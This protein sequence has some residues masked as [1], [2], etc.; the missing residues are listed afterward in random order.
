MSALPGGCEETARRRAEH[1]GEHALSAF[2]RATSLFGIQA[3]HL[4]IAVGQQRDRPA[5]ALAVVEVAVKEKLIAVFSK[6]SAVIGM[7]R[8][9]PLAVPVRHH[10]ERETTAEKRSEVAEDHASLAREGRR[11]V[12]NTDKKRRHG[13]PSTFNAC[14]GAIL[15]AR[16]SGTAHAASPTSSMMP[17]AASSSMTWRIDSSPT[18]AASPL[19]ASTPAP[20]WRNARE[21][22]PVTMRP[23][24]APS[25][26]RIP[27]SRVR[28]ATVNDISEWMPVAERSNTMNVINH[29]TAVSVQLSVAPP[30]SASP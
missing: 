6:Q 8:Q 24:P 7:R 30:T 1:V 10:G 3:V 12:M 19:P 28:R 25:A 11:A 13:Q 2:D 17:S 16:L 27:I 9:R 22:M 23:R 29:A 14:V 20:I 26:T 4:I 5:A 18:S 15:S 21:K